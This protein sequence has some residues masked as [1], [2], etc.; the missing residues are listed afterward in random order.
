MIKAIIFDCG[1]VWST[2][3]LRNMARDLAEKHN[4]DFK[5]LDKEIHRMWGKY[6][7][8]EISGDDFWKY[9]SGA[10]DT[11][12]SFEEMK[13]ISLSYIKIIPETIEIIKKLKGKYKLGLISN[14]AEEWVER[15][16]ELV[17]VGSLFDV[18]LFSNEVKVAKPDKEIFELC[19]KRLGALLPEE[20]IFIDDQEKHVEAAKNLG[21]NTIKFENAG[22]LKKELAKFGVET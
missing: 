2:T 3:I 16:K 1:G 8:A 13:S 15:I 20:C 14:N 17:D 22:I 12:E 7:L 19:I 21:F 11:G 6:K 4:A 10:A 9:F 5:F 18:A